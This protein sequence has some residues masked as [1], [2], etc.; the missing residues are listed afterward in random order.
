MACRL[1]RLILA[2]NQLSTLSAPDATARPPRLTKLRHLD[3]S[4]NLL[5]VWSDVDALSQLPAL[6]SLN[7]A[8]NPL[9]AG[10][11]EE[12]GGTSRLQL[13]GRIGRLTRVEGTPVSPTHCFVV[14]RWSLSVLA[15]LEM[16]PADPAD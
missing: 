9:L 14:A 5:T 11:E 13:I 10:E 15:D 4:N 16:G 12:R 6:E 3:L 2:N 8:G 1:S 7:I